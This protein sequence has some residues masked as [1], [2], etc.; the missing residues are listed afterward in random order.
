PE[1]A[2]REFRC[3]DIRAEE[4]GQITAQAHAGKIDEHAV[5]TWRGAAVAAQSQAQPQVSPGRR[6][7]HEVRARAGRRG[8]FGTP[9]AGDPPEGARIAELVVEQDRL[10]AQRLDFDAALGGQMP[11]ERD[12]VPHT[13]G[14]LAVERRAHP[15]AALVILDR[16]IGVS[17][18]RRMA[19]RI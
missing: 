6:M 16:T 13:R 15:D 10:R 17:R 3:D 8:F 4:G 5:D 2:I 18:G 7:E 19:T 14:D 1:P 12:S 9:Y 11:A